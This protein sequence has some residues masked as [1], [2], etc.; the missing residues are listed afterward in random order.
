M[1]SYLAEESLHSVRVF[2]FELE[3][4]IKTSH[5]V[6]GDGS[7]SIQERAGQS[8]DPNCADRVLRLI[9]QVYLHRPNKWHIIC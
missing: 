2:E 1:P 7:F 3:S 4:L 9:I 5:K 8:R 6:V